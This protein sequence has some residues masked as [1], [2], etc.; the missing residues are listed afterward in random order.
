M[1]GGALSRAVRGDIEMKFL[2]GLILAACLVFG[3]TH[4][5]ARVNK[6]HQKAAAAAFV[7]YGRSE[8]RE[9]DHHAL[10][11]AF[12]YQ[13]TPDGYV[14]LTAGHCFSPD[15]PKDATYL[16]AEGQVTDNP[17]LQPVEVWN[18][19]DNGVMDV[20]E[21]HL[22][23]TKVYPILELDEKPVKIDDKIFYVGYPEV[24][25]Q[26]VFTGRIAS[27]LIKS[28]GPDKSDPCDICIGRVLAQIGGGPGA[29]GSPVI[30]ERTGRVVGVLEGH[31]YENGVLVVPSTSINAYYA[32][33][34]HAQL[35]VSKNEQSEEKT[36]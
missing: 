2:R 17:V 1:N 6:N 25:S 5:D 33:V 8:E 26:V 11:T 13:K 30:S 4:A 10:C 28:Q 27:G 29:S 7:L 16:V 9:V 31:I 15:A 24:V 23:T 21:L 22:K 19:I 36:Q 14:L 12:A 32:K 3:V 35:S 34:G 18:H 20:A